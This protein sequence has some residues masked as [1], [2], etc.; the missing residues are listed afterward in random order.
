VYIGLILSIIATL[1]SVVGL[2]KIVI[3]NQIKTSD[4]TLS[5]I[6][7]VNKKVEKDFSTILVVC[8][9]LFAIAM[10]FYILPSIDAG[11]FLI[12]VW[13]ITIISELSL[14]FLPASHGWKLIAHNIISFI[15]ATS[16]FVL[17]II[18]AIY[19]DGI[20]TV[21]A[22]IICIAMFVLAVLAA[23]KR[24]NFVK[25]ELPYIFLSHMSVINLA[26]WVIYCN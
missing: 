8:G 25:Y 9:L 20:F 4:K 15:M 1:I 3:D 2:T 26:L 21:M 7:I 24:H 23:V 16:M 19:T 14:A 13:Y 22:T 5:K 18:F 10:Q 12:L 6:G 17:A 11:I